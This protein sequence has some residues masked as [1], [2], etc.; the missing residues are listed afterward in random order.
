MFI[1][2]RHCSRLFGPPA[3]LFGFSLGCPN[4]RLQ[5][6][7]EASELALEISFA[8]GLYHLDCFRSLLAMARRAYLCV[9]SFWRLFSCAIF[10]SET[11]KNQLGNS[12]QRNWKQWLK[13]LTNCSWC[14]SFAMGVNVLTPVDRIAGFSGRTMGTGR[15]NF[16]IICTTSNDDGGTFTH[17]KKCFEK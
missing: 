14:Q 12:K 11:Q 17:S 5:W 3:L 2:S 6:L 9:V 7:P 8:P 4:L 10:V 15:G 1:W 13:E 16:W